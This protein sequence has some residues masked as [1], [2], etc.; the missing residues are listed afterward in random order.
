VRS[1][2]E[3]LPL[4][5]NLLGASV[6][7]GPFIPSDGQHRVVMLSVA[8]VTIELMEPTN[9]KGFLA[10]ALAKR[11]EGFNHIGFDVDDIK[12]ATN[13]LQFGGLQV[14]R[15]RTDDPGLKYAFF[16]PKSFFGIELH[17]EED[18]QSVSD[19]ETV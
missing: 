9:D 17:L 1:I 19:I 7:F 2:D 3:A 6:L 15:E 8:G 16:H 10:R 13:V 11:G 18:W 12:G 4:F 5:Q 14:V